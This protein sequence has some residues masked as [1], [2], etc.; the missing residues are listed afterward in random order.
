[1]AGICEIKP[2]QEGDYN[3]A[4]LQLTRAIAKVN[5]T[6]NEGK[7]LEGVEITEITLHNYN[8][9]G[10]CAVQENNNLPYI[11][12][13]SQISTSTLSS[14]PLRGKEGYCFENHF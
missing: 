6:V 1:M 11:P 9:Q 4:E 8:T 2:L 14:G 10:Y 13:T 5:V 7:G 3:T 12:A